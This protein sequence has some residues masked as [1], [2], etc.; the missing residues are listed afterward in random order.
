MA[1][2]PGSRVAYMIDESDYDLYRLGTAW[3]L[4][5]RIAW[6]QAATW[7]GPFTRM[8]VGEVPREVLT[9]PAGYRKNWVAPAV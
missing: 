5:D 4:V 2:I 9:I 7:A 6:Y 3:Y 8:D 1:G